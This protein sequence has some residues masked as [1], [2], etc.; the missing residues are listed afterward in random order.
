MAD[1]DLSAEQITVVPT[2]AIGVTKGLRWT[3]DQ[4][5]SS[6]EL[7]FDFRDGTDTYLGSGQLS[8]SDSN[9]PS[10]TWPTAKAL[11]IDPTKT[12]EELMASLSGTPWGQ[13]LLAEEWRARRTMMVDG[14]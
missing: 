4:S 10:E 6:I 14:K 2:K 13:A 9:V 11:A 12:A 3:R 8:L 7:G 5:L 1:V